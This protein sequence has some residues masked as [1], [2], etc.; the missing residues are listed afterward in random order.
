MTC[1]I[2]VYSLCWGMRT[3]VLNPLDRAELLYGAERTP[4]TELERVGQIA[5]ISIARSELVP[6]GTAVLMDGQRVLG[7]IRLGH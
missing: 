7:V 4:V 5:G 3:Y 6:E 2:C 1:D